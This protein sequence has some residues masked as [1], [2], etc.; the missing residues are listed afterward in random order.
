MFKNVIKFVLMASVVAVFILTIVRIAFKSGNPQQDTL[1]VG[2]MSGWAPFMTVNQVGE[3]EG[4]DVDVAQKI[5][6]KLEKRLV[7]KDFG[8]LSTLLVALQ[9]RKIDFVMSG[10]DITTNRLQIMDMIPYTGQ[11]FKSFYLLFW[12]KIPEGVSSIQDLQKRDLKSPDLQDQ[13]LQKNT[14]FVVCAEPGSAQAK[15]LDQFKFIEQKS[16]SKIEDMV[17]DI[18]YGKSL[19]MIAEPQVALRFIRKNPELKKLELALP[20]DFQTFGMGIG[21]AKNSSLNKNTLSKKVIA[22]IQDMRNDGT[23]QILENKW[24]LEIGEQK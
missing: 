18:K 8:S 23:L 9:Q 15:Y 2:M 10:L 17:L 19:A 3:F 20:K 7:I 14:K 6:N 24:G 11:D 21:F 4:F 16:L 5:A 13:D 22:I 1:V 12:N